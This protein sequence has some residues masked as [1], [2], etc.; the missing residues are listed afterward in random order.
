MSWEG[1]SMN[2]D[3]DEEI[4]ELKHEQLPGYRNIFLVVFALALIYLGIVFFRG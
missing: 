2:H 4:M 1:L 3:N